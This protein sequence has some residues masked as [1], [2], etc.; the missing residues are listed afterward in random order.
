M[1]NKGWMLNIF[2]YISSK[3]TQDS[4]AVKC[5]GLQPMYLSITK[6]L[7]S[8]S[9]PTH[10]CGPDLISS[11]MIS[12]FTIVIFSLYHAFIQPLNPYTCN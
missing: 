10:A 4:T 9:K 5:F 11:D 7:S 6:F 8:L 12:N 2:V 1:N 3:E